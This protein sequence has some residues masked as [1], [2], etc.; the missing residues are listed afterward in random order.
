ML[1]AVTS[2]SDT[3]LGVP[4]IQKMTFEK[5][6]WRKTGNPRNTCWIH[7]SNPRRHGEV[8]DIANGVDEQARDALRRNSRRKNTR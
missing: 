2:V 5:G 7:D 6:P 1:R 8:S 3:N 4:I